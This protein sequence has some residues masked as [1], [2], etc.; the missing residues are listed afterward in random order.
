MGL[1]LGFIQLIDRFVVVAIQGLAKD[2]NLFVN[3]NGLW[4]GRYIPAIYRCYPF[5]FAVDDEGKN[6][7][8]IDEG[9][10]QVAENGDHVGFFDGDE[11]LTPETQTMLDSLSQCKGGRTAADSACKTL[12]EAN[13]IEPWPIQVEAKEGPREV[14]GLY[15]ISESN[16]TNLSAV[17]LKKL[18]RAG[19]L[20]LAYC[21]LLSM[22]H[23]NGLLHLAKAEDSI[24]V[25][26]LELDFGESSDSGSINFDNI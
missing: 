25:G 2:S 18:Q 21:Q 7:L 22:T 15:R 24:P 10:G 26:G 16:L 23:L 4:E 8:C 5:L 14:T 1:P 17:S 6:I 13:L 19:A 3:N 11:K 12:F 20:S 9:S